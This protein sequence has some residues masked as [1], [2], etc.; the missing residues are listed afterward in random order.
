[1]VDFDP[2]AEGYAVPAMPDPDHP[3]MSYSVQLFDRYSV[4][5]HSAAFG[6]SDQVQFD[7]YGKPTS[8]GSVVLRSGSRQR[9]I[10]VDAAG[11][12]RIL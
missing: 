9:T 5:V 12:V 8:S 2:A 11:Q 4:V 1:L 10:E 6:A 3:S 7:M